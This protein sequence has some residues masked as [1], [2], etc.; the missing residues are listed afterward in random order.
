MHVAYSSSGLYKLDRTSMRTH[1][2]MNPVFEAFGAE[3]VK[4]IKRFLCI[5]KENQNDECENGQ[6]V[7]HYNHLALLN[8]A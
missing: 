6:C 4:G 5:S 1:S 7:D 2:A 3:G 8:C